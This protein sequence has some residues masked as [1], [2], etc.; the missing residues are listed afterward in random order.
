MK[1]KLFILALLFPVSLLHAPKA[2]LV[3]LINDK[4]YAVATEMECS[5][6]RLDDKNSCA[7]CLMEHTAL[8]PNESAQNSIDFCTKK[9]TLCTSH[10]LDALKKTKN[11]KHNAS[12]QDLLTTLNDDVIIQPMNIG[13]SLLDLSGKFTEKNLANFLALAYKEKKLPYEEFK[14]AACLRIKNIAQQ[15]GY[16]TLQLFLVTSTC[17]TG[18]A[19]LYIIKES[20]DGIKE[21]KSLKEIGRIHA[22]KEIVAPKVKTGLP[23]LSLPIAYFSYPDKTTHYISTMPS[24]KGKVLS[25]WA[26]EYQKNKSAQNK[27]RLNRAFFILGKETSNF[28]KLFMRPERGKILG[29]TIAHGDFHLHNLFFDEISGHFT[30]ID[31]ETIALY[32]KNRISPAIDICKPFFL[33]FN[34][35]YYE[36][37]YMMEGVDLRDW[38][39]ITLKNF[40][41]GYI[42]PY[43]TKDHPQILREMK[44]MFEVFDVPDWI[45]FDDVDEVRAKIIN[46]IFG[47]LLKKY[48]IS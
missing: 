5:Q 38:Y 21:A 40:L 12:A 11:M 39:N 9:A 3:I 1:N 2:P 44:E 35:Q 23:S 10:S 24:A 37:R 7:C 28:H 18:P 33:P 42:N 41:L 17:T 6:K 25:Y 47:Q 45:H 46:P 30:F 22:F 13:S 4:T 48:K 16:N 31:N 36:F 29:K 14:N 19:S 20:K 27:E 8:F 15:G 26:L 34:N 43:P 32:I